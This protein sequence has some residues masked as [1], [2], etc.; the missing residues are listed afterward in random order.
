M[1]VKVCG[2]STTEQVETCINYDADYC[3]FILNYPK[4]HRYIKYNTADKLTKINKRNTKYVGVLVHPTYEELAKFSK[5]NIDYYQI[6]GNQK[7]DEINDIKQKYKVKIIKALTIE[8]EE[9]VL[10]YKIYEEVS[11]II[12]F[13]SKGYEQSLSFSHSLID[14][15]PQRVKKMI[16]GNI[17]IQDLEKISKI[18]DIV[19]VSGAVETN[20]K[21][22]LTK[23]KEFLLKVK[24]INENRTI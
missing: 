2:L 17:Q 9:D 23:I 10:K 15:V 19:D 13:D 12:L 20:K 4:S 7:P 16:A 6:Y 11:D 24:E 22:D 1:K 14:N 8:T 21:K 5:L 18:A 3:G